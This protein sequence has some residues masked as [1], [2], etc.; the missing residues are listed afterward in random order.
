M[1]ADEG[2]NKHL[3][4][5]IPTQWERV[6]RSRL[7]GTLLIVGAPD[8]GKSTFARYLYRC[9]YAQHERVAFV[10]GDVGQ[11]TLGPPTTMTLAL[12]GSGDDSFPP[13][14]P[15]FRAF[16]G[17]VSPRRHMLPMVVNAHM[18]VQKAREE[19][20]STVVFDTTGLVDPSHGGGALKRAQVDLLRPS[21]VVAIQRG[22]ELEHLLCPLRRSHRTRVIDLDVARCVR[23]RDVSVRQ[24]HRATRFRRYFEGS[25]NLEIEGER[26]AV[27]PGLD[28]ADVGRA[29]ADVGRA[30]ADVGHASVDVGRAV[31]VHRLVGLEDNEGFALA[32]GIVVTSDPGRGVITLYTPLPSLLNVD[33]VHLGNLLLDPCTFRGV[34]LR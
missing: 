32:L 5:E 29:S 14:G 12:G 33:A 3:R 16:V 21:V 23:R 20:V 1:L 4:F 30:S 6:A 28:F 27:F 17:D 7:S 26:L 19:G 22:S 10:D 11:A 34:R 18:L 9:L 15:R 25:R 2:M 24:A 8:T 31:R 13:A